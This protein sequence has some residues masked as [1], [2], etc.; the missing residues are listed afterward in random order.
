MFVRVKTSPNSPRKGVQICENERINGKV[1]QRIIRHVGVAMN[2]EQLQDLKNLATSLIPQLI[3]ETSGMRPL[4]PP[5]ELQGMNRAQTN[6][7]IRTPTGDKE[8]SKI[9]LADVVEESRVI[10]GI[11]DIYGKLFEDLGFNGILAEK[12]QHTLKSVVLARLANPC[13]KRATSA[14]LEKDFGIQIPL[15]KIYRMMDQLH[16]KIQLVKKTTLTATKSLFKDKINIAFFDVTTLSFESKE[17]DEL[18]KFGYSKDQKFHDTPV[19]ALATTDHGLPVGYKLFPGNTA[20]VKTLIACL[21]EWKDDF[22]ISHVVFVADRAMMSKDN[23]SYLEQAGYKYV[24]AAKIRTMNAEIKNEVLKE[25]G[26]SIFSNS[27]QLFW[28]KDIELDPLDT[29][30]PGSPKRR[31]VCSYSSKRA[32]K[33]AKD[34]DKILDRLTKLLSKK[35]DKP[36]SL[37]SNSGYKK[38]TVTAGGQA[39][40]STSKI[41]QDVAWDGIH[42]LITNS[43]LPLEDVI[44]TYHRLWVIEESFRITKHDISARPIFHFTPERIESHIAICFIAYTLARQAQYRLGLQKASFSIQ[45]IRDELLHV[46][47]S[48]LRDT[49]NGGY[50]LLPSAMSKAAL[51]IYR[52]FGIKRHLKPT[53]LKN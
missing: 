10:Q 19:L 9:S 1:R 37:V 32:Q 26:Y 27:K 11:Q 50:Y 23:L 36:G 35:N 25:D 12:Y 49:K 3:Q 44:A 17:V 30:S 29:K 20:E 6:T 33:D 51:D 43:D 14:F 34:R 53:S 2:D 39:S 15:E 8:L 47:A 40:I 45:K 48:I 22:E 41:N 42:G 52:V 16:P 31:L 38:F 7:G 46:Q 28:A 18:R 4:F 24:I 5:E 21:N 13:S